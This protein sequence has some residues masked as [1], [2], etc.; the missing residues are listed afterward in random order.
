MKILMIS[1]VIETVPPKKYGGVELVVYNLTEGLVKRGHSVT[2][3]APAESKTSAK[4]IPNAP[5]GGMRGK[6]ISEV[7]K[8][9]FLQAAK[10]LQIGDNFDII[11][12]H[13]GA[14]VFP[15]GQ[16]VHLVKTPI[17]FT[18]HG[19]LDLNTLREFYR[20]ERY[21][22]LNFISISN[23]QR[24]ALPE[25]NYLAT[26]YNGIEV[27]NFPFSEKSKDYLIFLGRASPEKGI[28]PAIKIAKKLNKKLHILAKV[29]PADREYFEKKVKPLIDNKLIIFHGEVSHDEKIKWLSKAKCLLFPI[30]WREPFGLV[31]IEA[32]ACGVPV[33]APARA[34]TPEIIIDG[35]TGF[36]VDPQNMIE[37]SVKVFKKIDEIKRIDCRKH[38]EEK[39]T[40][41]KMVEEYLKIYRK[42][43]K[44]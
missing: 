33:I 42:L 1:P 38:V 25:L 21:R 12:C 14:D 28:V 11:H 6:P 19:R 36:L 15:F 4:L 22:K 9:E 8:A 34:S 41:E 7:R 27:E 31:M 5:D 20:D 29:D 3:F 35:K 2:L 40:A 37:E 16:I 26:I 39:F 32:M 24:G 30:E 13:F 23:D 10:M 17:L 43:V 44:K 18:L